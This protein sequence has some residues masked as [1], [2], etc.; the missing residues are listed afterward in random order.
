MNIKLAYWVI[1]I[2]I[3]LGLGWWYF[4]PADV[5]NDPLPDEASEVVSL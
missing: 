1:G 3:V 4:T 2:L 5:P